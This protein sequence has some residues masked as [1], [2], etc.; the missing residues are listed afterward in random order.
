MQKVDEIIKA[1]DRC[2]SPAA[3]K[4]I[5]YKWGTSIVDEC[6]IVAAMWLS[7]TPGFTTGYI[8]TIKKEL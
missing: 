3:K 4:D 6:S 8:E 5:L 7:V 2:D 1:I